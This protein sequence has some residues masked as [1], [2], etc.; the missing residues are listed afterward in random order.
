MIEVD[1]ETGPGL[2]G[3]IERWRTTTLGDADG[4]NTFGEWRTVSGLS[5]FFGVLGFLDGEGLKT[6]GECR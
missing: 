5:G 4:L 2:V 1:L 3:G 6:G